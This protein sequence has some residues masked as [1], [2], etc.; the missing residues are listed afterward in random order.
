ML[1]NLLKGA[2]NFPLDIHVSHTAVTTGMLPIIK[3]SEIGKYAGA[4]KDL[5]AFVRAYLSFI[6][7]STAHCTAVVLLLRPL[8]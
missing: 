6:I 1:G 4:M 8:V 3:G 2:G 7:T 5:L